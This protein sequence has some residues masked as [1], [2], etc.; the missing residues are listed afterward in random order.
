MN[1]TARLTATERLTKPFANERTG[2][3]HRKWRR[4]IFAAKVCAATS[5][6]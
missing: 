3:A 1:L 6:T 4:V 5:V 2:L